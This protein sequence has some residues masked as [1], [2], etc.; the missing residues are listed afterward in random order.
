M[1]RLCVVAQFKMN[2]QKIADI[3]VEVIETGRE[4]TLR[5][6]A[7]L[8]LKDCNNP[9]CEFCMRIKEALNEEEPCT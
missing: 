4:E 2:P 8:E 1:L 9:E 5:A 7:E 3:L 6:H